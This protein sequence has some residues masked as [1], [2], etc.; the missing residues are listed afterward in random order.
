MR[1][2]RFHRWILGTVGTACLCLVTVRGPST[3]A[4]E[5]TEPSARQRHLLGL[6]A[7]HLAHEC[8]RALGGEE[9]A[10]AALQQLLL[11]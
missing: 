6:A 9:L 5:A 2:L 1:S 8:G 10:G 11:F 3:R 4:D 7:H